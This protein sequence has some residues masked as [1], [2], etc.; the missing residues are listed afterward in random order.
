MSQL[1]DLFWQLEYCE[2]AAVTPTIE[3]AKLALVTSRDE[4]ED[5][6][7]KGGT[8]SSNDTDATLVDDGPS[9]FSVS[10][11]SPAPV[12]PNSVL[13]KRPRDSER[14]GSEMLV[15]SP[16]SESKEGFVM[17]SKPIPPSRSTSPPP[18]EHIGP[19]TSK[20]PADA[21]DIDGDVDMDGDSRIVHS[22]NNPPPL[23]PRKPETSDSVMM[24][25][26]IILHPVIIA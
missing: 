18:L 8:D 16:T 4:E 22:Q 2:T 19:S 20:A 13:G 23:P 3:L 9:R 25:G 12:S 1:A 24:F 26:K 14:Q 21:I 10:E 7:D 11:A 17:I 6:V 15:D 5:E